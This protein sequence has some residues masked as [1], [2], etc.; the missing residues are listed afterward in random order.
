MARKRVRAKTVKS[1]RRKASGKK[2]VVTKVNKVNSIKPI[3]GMYAYDVT[4]KAKKASGRRRKVRRRK[5][6]R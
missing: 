1:A 2:T 5:K 4:T 3:R 6:R